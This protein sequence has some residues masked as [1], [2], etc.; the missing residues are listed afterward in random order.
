MLGSR[1]CGVYGR[2]MAMALHVLYSYAWIA[3]NSRQRTRD[4]AVVHSC[5]GRMERPL[6]G[7]RLLNTSTTSVTNASAKPIS[8]LVNNISSKVHSCTHA[9][10]HKPNYQPLQLHCNAIPSTPS[11]SSAASSRSQH[12]SLAQTPN[13]STPTQSARSHPSLH[14]ISHPDSLSKIFP[15][16]LQPSHSHHQNLQP[17]HLHLLD[18]PRLPA[19]RQQHLLPRLLQGHFPPQLQSRKHSRNARRRSRYLRSNCRLD[20]LR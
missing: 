20:I 17:P 19:R 2:Q 18:S 14:F 16:H 1:L 4:K 12:S 5:F 10:I 6:L 11:T 9:M 7:R 15:N 3:M 8:L 13:F